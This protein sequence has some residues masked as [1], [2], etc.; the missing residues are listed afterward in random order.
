MHTNIKLKNNIIKIIILMVIFCLG[1]VGGIVHTRDKYMQIG[2]K[3]AEAMI[4]IH[5]PTAL[6]KQSYMTQEERER[7][8][9][10]RA[11]N[12]TN[13]SLDIPGG[14]ND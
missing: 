5:C 9:F 7:R 4:N 10:D 6:E 1:F 12:M 13:F 2:H 11:F 8:M 3:Y 14:K